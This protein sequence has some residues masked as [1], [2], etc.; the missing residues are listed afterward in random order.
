MIDLKNMS[1]KKVNFKAA[2][3]YRQKLKELKTWAQINGPK[4][5]QPA[6]N[7]TLGWL[8][9]ELLGTGFRMIEVSDFAMKGLIPASHLNLDANEEVNQGLVL[10]ASLELSKVFIN[11][12]MPESFY[13]I[14]SSEIKII[15]NQIWNENLSL[16]LISSDSMMDHFFSAMQENKKAVLH[17]AI[18]IEFEK[19]KKMDNIDLKL[20]CEA[21]KLIA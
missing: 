7:Y 6:L 9:P 2:Q 10:N 20:V 18:R 13:K 16:N 12:H 8:S 4:P 19:S 21:T 5:L 15:K 14:S 1:F 11:R 3:T 17:F